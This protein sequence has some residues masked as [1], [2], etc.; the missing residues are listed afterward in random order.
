MNSASELEPSGPTE[1]T[2]SELCEQFFTA[3]AEIRRLILIVL[4]YSSSVPAN[5]PPAL[6]P[7]DV[8]QLEAAALQRNLESVASNLERALGIS[9]QLAH[10]I[11]ADDRGEPTV[12]AA[13]ALAIPA[14]VLQRI[15]LF[16]NPIVG[17]SVERVYKLALLYNEMTV[18]AARHLIDIWQDADPAVAR[19]PATLAAQ[20]QS[21]VN[22]ARQSLAEI[23]RRTSTIKEADA[24][25]Q[26]A[27]GTDA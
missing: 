22:R 16:M 9:Q 23:S 25:L 14:N 18:E 2:A 7:V 1:C 20:W 21:T 13:K 24:Y 12:V 19:K 10:R 5:P 26:R 4:D 3:D 8:W 27:N 15:L 11:I 6:R 17:Q